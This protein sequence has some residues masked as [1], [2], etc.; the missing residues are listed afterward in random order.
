[1][2]PLTLVSCAVALLTPVA[3]VAATP[4][5]AP[6]APAAASPVTQDARCLMIMGALTGAKDQSTAM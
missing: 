2:R 4:R 1:M 3:A 6:A 5:T